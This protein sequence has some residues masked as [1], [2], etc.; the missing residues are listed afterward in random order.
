VLVLS[1]FVAVPLVLVLIAGHAAAR[2]SH[3]TD[4]ELTARF[5]SHEADFE[6]LTHMLDSDRGRLPSANESADLADFVQA[7]TDRV[8][9][10]RYAVL[11]AGIGAT[12][13]RYFPRSGNLIVPVSNGG[14]RFAAIRKSYSYLSRE[15]QQP[16]LVHQ[17]YVPRGPAVYWATGD[18]RIKGRW[19]IHHD[20]TIGVA[21]APF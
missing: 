13:F 3:P 12:N 6:A 14:D 8:R 15:Q 10:D 17:S 4:D 19:F 1:L 20:A 21:F 5:L 9:I 16:L 2:A 11:L 18:H 7:G